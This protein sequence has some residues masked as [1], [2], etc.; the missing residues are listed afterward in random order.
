M[1]ARIRTFQQAS[2]GNWHYAILY[3]LIEVHNRRAPGSKLE[4][5][6]RNAAE[7][8]CALLGWSIS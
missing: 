1:K 3:N 7:A 2:D 8:A 6:A 5:L 4:K